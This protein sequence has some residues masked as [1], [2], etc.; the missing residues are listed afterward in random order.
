MLLCNFFK[1]IKRKRYKI[2]S[3]F[4]IGFHI[5]GAIFVLYSLI[6]DFNYWTYYM[7]YTRK[8]IG[9]KEHIHEPYHILNIWMIA[10]QIRYVITDSVIFYNSFRNNELLKYTI[11]VHGLESLLCSITFLCH[12]NKDCFI[13]GIICILWTLLWL[14]S[15][16][17]IEKNLIKIN[18]QK[19]MQLHDIKDK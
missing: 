15:Y 1:K 5:L 13:F 18:F 16:F 9:L 11:K 19:Y 8:F 14:F 4:S 3:L 7:E 17:V 2:F 12:Q 6:F 10:I